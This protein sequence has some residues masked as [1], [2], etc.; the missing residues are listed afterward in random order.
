MTNA[1]ISQTRMPDAKKFRFFFV[2]YKHS[3]V[4]N[5][6]GSTYP[7][8]TTGLCPYPPKRKNKITLNIK[9]KKIKR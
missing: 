2:V 9:N 8:G 1:E 5:K 4:D 6:Q 3:W 7:R